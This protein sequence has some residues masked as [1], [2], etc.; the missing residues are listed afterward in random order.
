MDT[1]KTFVVD[2]YPLVMLGIVLILGIA[3]LAAL[4]KIRGDLNDW[5][6]HIVE[7][8]RSI[9]NETEIIKAYVRET[10]IDVNAIKDGCE[11]SA[12]SLYRINKKLKKKQKKEETPNV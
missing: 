8:T 9:Y 11:D 3:V 10:H 7:N 4:I 5:M 2:W 6:M 1:F 12:E